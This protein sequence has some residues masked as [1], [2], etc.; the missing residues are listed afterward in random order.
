MC[1]LDTALQY[2]L[3]A[4]QH[5]APQY[6]NPLVKLLLSSIGCITELTFLQLS[7]KVGDAP[8]K[9]KQLSNSA[10]TLFLA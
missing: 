8:S 6:V 1:L 5:I 7:M 4:I 3:E 2:S 9:T 10:D